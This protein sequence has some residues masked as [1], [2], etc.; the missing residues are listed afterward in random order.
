MSRQ[1]VM[2]ELS[3]AGHAVHPSAQQLVEGLEVN[4]FE[5]DDEFV[6]VPMGSAT[7]DTLVVRGTIADDQ[8]HALRAA[9]PVVAVWKD[10]P[11]APF[12]PPGDADA[13]R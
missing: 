9:Q 2:V 10:T 7:G 3:A 13:P 12:G 6:P 4:G 11:V 1:E 8:V 5:L